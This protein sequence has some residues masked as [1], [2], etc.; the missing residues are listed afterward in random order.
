[1]KS[2]WRKYSRITIVQYFVHKYMHTQV[3]KEMKQSFNILLEIKTTAYVTLLLACKNSFG[4]KTFSETICIL[5]K[6]S[7]NSKQD[8]QIDKR[9]TFL[10]DDK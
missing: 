7:Y 10:D 2:R 8:S 4:F 1:M 6:K 9:R 3:G 5:T